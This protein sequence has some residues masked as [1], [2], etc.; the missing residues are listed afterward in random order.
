MIGASP[1]GYLNYFLTLSSCSALPG[2]GGGALRRNGCA[3]W[4]FLKN[5]LK[6]IRISFVGRE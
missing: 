4:K 1:T 3:R 2:G 5:T 6:V